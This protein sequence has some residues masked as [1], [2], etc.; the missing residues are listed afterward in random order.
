MVATAVAALQWGSAIPKQRLKVRESTGWRQRLE[1]EL[2]EI[3]KG[4]GENFFDGY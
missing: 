3:F 1:Q 4:H 2:R